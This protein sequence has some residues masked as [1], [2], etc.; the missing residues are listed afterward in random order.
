MDAPQVGCELS[1]GIKP[2]ANTGAAVDCVKVHVISLNQACKN[3][4]LA[5]GARLIRGTGGV[6][7]FQR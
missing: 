3:A 6:K 5:M 1:R 4:R 2:A 7:L